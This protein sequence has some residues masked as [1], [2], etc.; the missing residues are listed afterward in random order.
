MKNPT[1]TQSLKAKLFL[2]YETDP[3]DYEDLMILLDEYEDPVIEF[4]V[5]DRS[6]GWAK[7]RM[8][9]WEVRHY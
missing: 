8:V 4:S 7:R 5:L 3:S 6:V 2:Q 1:I 9:I